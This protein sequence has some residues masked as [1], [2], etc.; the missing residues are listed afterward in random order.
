MTKPLGYGG[1]IEDD[2]REDRVAE[3]SDSVAGGAHAHRTPARVTHK[4][5]PVIMSKKRHAVDGRWATQSRSVIEQ[6]SEKIPKTKS[7]G[8]SR[9]DL[10]GAVSRSTSPFYLLAFSTLLP[11]LTRK[12]VKRESQSERERWPARRTVLLLDEVG[13]AAAEGSPPGQAPVQ[14]SPSRGR[15]GRRLRTG[16]GRGHPGERLSAGSGRSIHQ[17]GSSS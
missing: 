2:R 3:G 11:R 15:R 16:S 4:E 8:A 10:Q 14:V 9:V 13:S 1:K 6:K 12:S 7:A 17:A 5:Q